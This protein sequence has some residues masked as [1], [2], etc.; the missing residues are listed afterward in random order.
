MS[1]IREVLAFSGDKK[2]ITTSGRG[3]HRPSRHHN[4]CCEQLQPSPRVRDAYYKI[5]L[6]IH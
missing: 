3:Y 6:E 4:N 2:G 1:S 5:E